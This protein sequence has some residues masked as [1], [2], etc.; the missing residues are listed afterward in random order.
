MKK[1]LVIGA[2]SLSSSM[3][4]ANQPLAI[5]Q[6]APVP[7][8]I[9]ETPVAET[10][11]KPLKPVKYKNEAALNASI[12]AEYSKY[13]ADLDGGDKVKLDGFALGV[14]SA[15]QRSGWYAKFE[16]LNDNRLDADYYEFVSG[17]QLNLFNYN[18]LYALATAGIGYSW[19][20]SSR[21]N[22]TVNF[23][24][25]PIGLELGYS[26][27]PELS[28]YG[29]IGYKWLWDSTSSTTCKDGTTSNSVG[30]GTCS[31]HNGIAYY[32]DY[33]GDNDGV[34]YKAGLRYNF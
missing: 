31:S 22:N 2:L 27:I 6:G 14:S 15:P 11:Y 7:M 19:A 26:I 29:G 12:Y 21:L 8:S 23:V 33:V 28:V 34:T 25:L 16:A 20:D 9:S 32:N 30:S 5:Q 18:G 1:Y 3:G 4:F 10:Q 24:T 13:E 17:G